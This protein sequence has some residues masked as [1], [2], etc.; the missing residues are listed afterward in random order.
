MQRP[1]TIALARMSGAHAIRVL[2]SESVSGRAIIEATGDALARVAADG[3]PEDAEQRA[4]GYTRRGYPTR[5]V[6]ASDTVIVVWC[7][8]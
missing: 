7:R 8:P 3:L 5:A 4:Y 6:V 1:E 2:C